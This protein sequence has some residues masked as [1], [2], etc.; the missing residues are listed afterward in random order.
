ESRGIDANNW[1]TA[2]QV[3]ASLVALYEGRLLETTYRDYLL[4]DAMAN[5][6]PGL[7]YL[8][9][10]TPGGSVSHKNGFFPMTGGGYVDNDAG[11]VFFERDGVEYAYAVTFLS[12]DVPT[13][14]A[15][16]PLAQQLVTLTW[17]YFDQRYS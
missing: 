11:I 3:N 5:V 6:K 8:V 16:I 15:E 1:V 17:E 7:N 14:Y 13:K 4:F 12:S 2:E 9:G 10:A